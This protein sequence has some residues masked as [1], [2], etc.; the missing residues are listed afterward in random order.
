MI[1]DCA[2]KK[3]RAITD[4]NGYNYIIYDI[5]HITILV[6]WVSYV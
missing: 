2:F 4:S 1:T 3:E 6:L 5:I